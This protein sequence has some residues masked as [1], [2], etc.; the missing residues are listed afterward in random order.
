MPLACPIIRFCGLQVIVAVE[1]TLADVA[2]PI[3]YGM[4][5]R[6]ARRVRSITSGVNSRQIGSLRNNAD[7]TPDATTTSASSIRGEWARLSTRLP[8]RSKNPA[9]HK[10]EL[11]SISEQ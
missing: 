2:S 7:N 6:P 1:P 10:L 5:L 9:K 4:G 8:T 11:R 3:R